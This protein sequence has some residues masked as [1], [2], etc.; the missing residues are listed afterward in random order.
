MTQSFFVPRIPGR[1]M[2]RPRLLRLMP[3]ADP[4]PLTVVHAPAG[5]GKST[6]LAQWAA[7]SPGEYDVVW[8]ALDDSAA[9]RFAFWRTVIDRVLESSLTGS[10]TLA[11][12]SPASPVAR[13]L[14]DSLRRGFASLPRPLTLVLD[15]FHL[16]RDPSVSDDLVWLLTHVPSLSIVISARDAGA[17]TSSSMRSLIDLTAVGPETLAL[18]R[19]EVAE[20]ARAAGAEES[21]A[22]GV[23]AATQGWPMLVR[24]ALLDLTDGGS[25]ASR[26]RRGIGGASARIADQLIEGSP[27]QRARFILRTSLASSL[28]AELAAALT[29]ESLSTAESYLVDLE[30]LALGTFAPAT[31]GEVFRYHPLLRAEFERM[32]VS[33]SPGD[34]VGI[35]RTI[36]QWSS[37]SGHPLEAAQQAVLAQDWEL[38]DAIRARHGSVLTMTHPM[39]YRELLGTVPEEILERY[40]GL[41]LSRSLL[42]SRTDRKLPATIRQIGGALASLAAARSARGAH[43]SPLGRLWN[44]GVVMILHRLSG[45]ETAALDAAADVARAI[46][47]LKTDDRDSAGSYVALA[48]SHVA[49]TLLHSGDYEAALH[50]AELDLDAAERYGNEWEA[51]H[52][53]ALGSWALALEGDITRAEQWLERA[54]TTTRPDGWQDS[55]AGTGYRLAE[56]IVAL[57]RFD[58]VEAERHLRALDYHAPTIEHWPFLAQVDA[59]IALTR[60]TAADGVR[61]LTS[62]AAARRRRTTFHHLTAV[63]ASTRATLDSALGDSRSAHAIDGVLPSS[64]IVRVAQARVA[65]VD[66]QFERALA[67]LPDGAVSARTRAEALLVKALA[68]QG[69]G[70]LAA[71]AEALADVAVLLRRTGLRQPLMLVPRA[72][73]AEAIEAA[74]SGISL[75]GVPD[76]FGVSRAVGS[77]TRREL[78]VLQHLARN[79]SLDTIATELVVS[80]NT[81]KGQVSS[82]Y[83]KLGVNNRA[84]AIVVA[85]ELGL[86]GPA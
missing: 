22:N 77:L 53:L 59:H 4:H 19:D 44:L 5:M 9:G 62:M 43:Q 60:G 76:R 35:R 64:P 58:T 29:G 55:Y 78:V 33:R 32:Q 27:E 71:S 69:L 3:G 70:A 18:T 24:A 39:T 13:T 45:R 30:S 67:L 26:R 54:R 46:N 82:L 48:H 56:A 65:L 15:D 34:L 20:L 85:S 31:H 11:D 52:A 12:V 50:H 6:L 41:Q 81:V 79:G 40:P 74:G 1:L 14:R 75:E 42:S 73:L 86:I 83:R 68:A 38:L 51:V 7:S 23:F 66:G 21:A 2:N 36:A 47:E 28:T 17:F 63:V 61:V 16:V 80:R 10:E 25:E 8:V 84:E 57:E 72:H 49:I 37:E